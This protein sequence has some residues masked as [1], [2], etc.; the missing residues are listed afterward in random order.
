MTTFTLLLLFVSVFIGLLLV[1]ANFAALETA[2]FVLRERR[3]HFKDD[4]RSSQ[5]MTKLLHE[6]TTTLGEVLL[7]GSGANLLLTAV[8]LYGI[9]V[10]LKK[11]GWT[12]WVSTPVIFGVAL[13]VVEIL[14]R[15]LALRSPKTIARRTLPLFR[16]LRRL[17]LPFTLPLQ[18]ISNAIANRLAPSKSRPKLHLTH[19]EMI[20]LIDMRAEQGAIDLH[21]AAMVRAIS[22]LHR[23]HAKDIMTPRVDL[24]LMPFDAQDDEAANMLE[25]ARHPY[26]AVYD[27]KMDAIAYLI[28]CQQWKLTGRPHWS[29]LT[30]K[31]SFVPE[32]LSLLDVW[33]Q[34]LQHSPSSVVVVVDEYG[35]FEGLLTYQDVIHHLLAK[36]APSSLS[37]LDIQSVGNNRYL[38][39]GNTRIHEVERELDITLNAEGVDTIGG[40]VMNHFGYPPKPGQRIQIKGMEF[41]VKRTVRA[42]VQQVEL[43]LLDESRTVS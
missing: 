36:A 11:L 21:E 28:S 20:T 22:G 41:K 15:T 6:P 16:V 37:T 13:V 38:I 18:G 42:R 14:P 17:A 8:G 23:L 35:G 27:E 1:A 39:M 24:P 33:Q 25:S 4:Q 12:P 26:T 2:L 34:H 10:P 3:G 31:P 30:L 5:R 9:L 7:L 43:T 29:T 19:D 32:T 40:L